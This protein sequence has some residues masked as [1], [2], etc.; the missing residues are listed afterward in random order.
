M[1]DHEIGV[2]SAHQ[3]GTCRMS[4]SPKTGA[5]DPNG[6]LWECD[7]LFVMDASVFPTASGS[8]PMVT[9]VSV[10]YMLSQRLCQLLKLRNEDDPK[11]TTTVGGAAAGAPDR[12]QAV[13]LAEKRREMRSRDYNSDGTARSLL[14]KS[15]VVVLPVVSALLIAR[16][17]N[18]R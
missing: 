3:M 16:L 6:E 9:V 2:F 13:E 15:S 11:G 7:D 18:R 1:T 4:S 17:L 14:L 12:A 5:V 10:S 8:N